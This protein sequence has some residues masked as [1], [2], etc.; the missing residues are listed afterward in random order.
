MI[1][2]H[3]TSAD[4][5]KFDGDPREYIKRG[6]GIYFYPSLEMASVF[7]LNKWYDCDSGLVDGSRVYE[8]EVHV[9]DDDLFIMTPLVAAQLQSYARSKDTQEYKDTLYCIRHDLHCRGYLGL[10]ILVAREKETYR[11]NGVVLDVNEYR[12]EQYCIFDPCHITIKSVLQP[13]L[14]NKE[15]YAFKYPDKPFYS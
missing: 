6:Y 12:E 2:Y 10:K 8:C 14:L 7:C 5:T 1:L 13:N 9:D 4:I 11:G 15:K 3:G